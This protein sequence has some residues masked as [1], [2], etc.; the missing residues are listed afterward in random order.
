MDG[1]SFRKCGESSLLTPAGGKWYNTLVAHKATIVA[2]WATIRS[3][4]G[5]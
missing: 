3:C 1:K 5:T 4:D 2:R